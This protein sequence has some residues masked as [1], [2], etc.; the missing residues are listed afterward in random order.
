MI[1]EDY[2]I[3][4]NFI[5]YHKPNCFFYEMSYV[6]QMADLAYVLRRSLSNY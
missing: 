6:T 4:L 3:Y 1:N 5:R 2:K